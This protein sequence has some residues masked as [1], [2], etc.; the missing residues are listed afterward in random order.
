[1]SQRPP[2]TPV[3]RSDAHL[4]HTGLVELMGGVPV[5]CLEMPERAVEI[6]RALR[7][8][9]GF[10]FGDPEA[11]GHEPILAVHDP[12][13][14]D[15]VD[16]AWADALAAGDIDGT[17]PLIPDTFKLEAYVGPMPLHDEP[18]AAHH[19][20]GAFCFDTATPIVAGTAAAARAAVDVALT[21]A[22]RV[23]DG[24]PLA[25]GLCRPPGHHAA[26]RMLGGYCFFNNAAI[27]AEWLRQEA[28]FAKVAILDVDYHHGNGTQQLFWER[29]D[30][31]YVSL[32]ADPARAYP[33]Y[34]GYVAERGAGPGTR[35]NLNLPLP[36]QAGI[37]A[38][39]EALEQGLDA[40][41][42]FAPDA[43][44][45]L[46]LGFDTFERDPIGDLA[47]RTADYAVIG[48]RVASLGMPVAALQEGGYA[49]DAIGANAVGFLR[50]LRGEEA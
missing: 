20:L 49:I 9:G 32:H 19:R 34:S 41:R 18:A 7:A 50:G 29:G 6:E 40:I 21:A 37:D 22:R 23:V 4:A 1:M 11:F 33:Y 43:P 44:L 5:P 13:L 16:H 26:R 8:D 31:L 24:A 47:L 42:A 14:L 28:G 45:V 46:S 48:S 27:V 39:R 30:V 35:A 12:D 38:Y 2:S 25:Y 36:P 10:A 15:V 3:I 17:R